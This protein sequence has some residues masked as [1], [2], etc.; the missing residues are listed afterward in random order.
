MSV[1]TE[2]FANPGSANP[3]VTSGGT[4]TPA[5][6]TSE[7]WTITGLSGVFPAVS[8]SASPPTFCRCVDPNKPTEILWITNISGTTATVT[9]GAE[10]TATVNHGSNFQLELLLT[11]GGLGNLSQGWPGEINTVAS[12]TAN[13]TCTAS[14]NVLLCNA[15]SGAFTITLPT[16]VGALGRTYTVKKTDS[17]TSAVTIATTSSQTIDGATTRAI[18]LQYGYIEVT[19]DGSNWQ[20]VSWY[21]GTDPWHDLAPTL[22]G[23]SQ[24][25]SAH[26]LQYR[27]VPNMLNAVQL[28]G[29]VSGTA[30]AS[31]TQTLCYLPSGYYPTT[32]AAEAMV[33]NSSGRSVTTDVPN[34][35]IGTDGSLQLRNCQGAT[36]LQFDCLFS[37]D[38]N[39]S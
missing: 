38:V 7:S 27:F 34:V 17:S 26:P 13:Y 4:T 11:G 3:V 37:L 39:N 21:N 24:R 14:D 33:I 16:A 6:G 15:S 32:Y 8:S 9:R 35:T 10:S 1:T 36:I 19:S 18:S 25:S 30:L 12:K 5:S 2:L 22:S 31:G 20:V 29:S 28:V 23:W